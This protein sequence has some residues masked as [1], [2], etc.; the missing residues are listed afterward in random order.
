V[1]LAAF[2]IFLI[3]YLGFALSPNVALI[4]VLFVL[5]G[6]YQGIFRAVGKALASDYVP[7]ELRASGVGWYNTIV[8]VCG[9][10]ASLVGGWLWD[11]VGH[12]SVFLFGAAFAAIGAVALSILV[13]ANVTAQRSGESVS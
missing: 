1:L 9:L 2:G 4:A 5:Y 3:T 6:L 7:A 12:A 13:P 8:G 10:V 11:H